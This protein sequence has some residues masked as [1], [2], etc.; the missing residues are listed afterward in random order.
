MKG[1]KRK[2]IAPNARR[3]DVTFDV[4]SVIDRPRDWWD[5]PDIGV[6]SAAFAALDDGVP[7]LFLPA[8]IETRFT[9]PTGTQAR[10]LKVRVYPDQVHVDDHDTGL[11]P[12]EIKI[13]RAYWRAWRKAARRRRRGRQDGGTH[14]ADDAAPGPPGGVGGA[15]HGPEAQEG[16]PD[17]PRRRGRRG[18]PASPTAGRWS[19]SRARRTGASRRSSSGGRPR[20]A[21]T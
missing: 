7:V 8:R 18:R 2:R 1:P 14:L 5:L 15:P 11:T 20:S 21:T 12:R 17:A 3:T 4:P 16:T 9:D 10:K 6:G 13:G 19:A